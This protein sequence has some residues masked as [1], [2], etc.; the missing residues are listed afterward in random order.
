MRQIFIIHLSACLAHFTILCTSFWHNAAL[1]PS[2]RCHWQ[3]YLHWSLRSPPGIDCLVWL[4][5]LICD[6]FLHS[7]SI[8]IIL[9]LYMV[10]TFD[11]NIFNIHCFLKYFS[12]IYK[13]LHLNSSNT[14]FNFLFHFFHAELI[15]CC[16][17][18]SVLSSIHPMSWSIQFNG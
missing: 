12:F 7:F 6:H 2:L 18:Q 9:S 1:R 17:P 10:S 5:D 16:F 3:Y 11:N 8:P 15:L 13:F 14:I 4:F